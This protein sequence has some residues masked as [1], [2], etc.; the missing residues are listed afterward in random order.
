MLIH[1]QNR[2]NKG[3]FKAIYLH[4]IYLQTQFD[5]QNIGCNFWI[6]SEPIHR[7]VQPL[8]VPKKVLLT[9]KVSLC[10]KHNVTSYTPRTERKL[11]MDIYY[12][13]II[14]DYS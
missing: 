13:K 2:W 9:N 5:F 7:S 12:P 10:L 8:L 14:T 6:V 3:Q 1:S 11:E 4:L